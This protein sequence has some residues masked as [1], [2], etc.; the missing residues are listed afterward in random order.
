[1]H[2]PNRTLKAAIGLLLLGSAL[3]TKISWAGDKLINVQGKLTNNAGNP[4]SGTKVVT[5]RLYSNRNDAA[6]NAVWTE[7]QSIALQSGGLFSVTLGS[8]TSL[9]T[10]SFAAPYYLGMQ[11]AGDANELTPR[12]ILGASTYALGSLGDFHVKKSLYAAG[13][14]LFSNAVYPTPAISFINDTDTGIAYSG[15]DDLMIITGGAGRMRFDSGGFVYFTQPVGIGT[16]G[17]TMTEKLE[18]VGNIKCTNLYQTSD[19]RFK[20]GIQGIPNVLDKV[21]LLRGVTYDW[22]KAEFEKATKPKKLTPEGETEWKRSRY[23]PRDGRQLGV[24][25][26]ELEPVFP[27]LVSTDADGYKAVD[28]GR[29][30]VILLEAVKEQQKQIDALKAGLAASKP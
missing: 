2:T 15:N 26:Q 20:S 18:V 3:S 6:A 30:T 10:V 9:D 25:A 29:L 23:V 19:L 14:A 13:Q 4:L 1:M 7:S 22:N 17:N 5:F 16:A 24:V 11:V 8:G 27:D 12:Q 28:Y 21:K